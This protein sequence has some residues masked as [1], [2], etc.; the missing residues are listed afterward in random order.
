MV[1]VNGRDLPVAVTGI[2]ID[3]HIAVT[4][5]AVD[6]L[7]IMSVRK[8]TTPINLANRL[9]NVEKLC[10]AANIGRVLL[11]ASTN[12]CTTHK[13]GLRRIIAGKTD[14]THAITVGGKIGCTWEVVCWYFLSKRHKVTQMQ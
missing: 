8:L 5:A 10:D 4:A 7:L 6:C 12:K 13:P 3:A 9:Q 11:G 1:H 2:V 14:C